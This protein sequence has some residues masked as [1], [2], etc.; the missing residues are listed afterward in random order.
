MREA[1]IRC[2]KTQLA[3]NPDKTFLGGQR[4]VLLGY[5]MSEKGREPDSEKIVVIDNLATPTNAIGIT[6][7]QGHVG[8]CRELIPD[9]AKI[10][11]PIT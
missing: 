2:R 4:G 8:W 7:L 6:K 9:Y 1:L 10:V 5:L 11:V 3:L